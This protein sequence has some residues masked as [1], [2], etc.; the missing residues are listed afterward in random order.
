MDPTVALYAAQ[1]LNGLAYGMLLFL[2]SSGLTLI[3]GMM[4]FFNLS[5]AFFFM[6][7]SYFSSTFLDMTGSF[8]MSLFLPPLAVAVTGI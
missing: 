7:A 1:A 6:L 5:H 2:V 4:G 8:W 3:Y